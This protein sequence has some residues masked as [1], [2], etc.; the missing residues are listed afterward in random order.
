MVE[1]RVLFWSLKWKYFDRDS[2]SVGVLGCAVG[3][4]SKNR[5][6]W[7]GWGLWCWRVGKVFNF[8]L[9]Y[10]YTYFPI[11]F[12]DWL[13]RNSHKKPKSEKEKVS[14]LRHA[15]DF[16]LLFLS[17]FT[18]R[19]SSLLSCKIYCMHP[20]TRAFLSLQCS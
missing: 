18:L 16:F 6:L 15:F 19:A 7:K 17:F 13:A 4:I 5:N 20:Q 8:L 1:S 3:S 12:T 9:K 11:V 10:I 14:F 2:F